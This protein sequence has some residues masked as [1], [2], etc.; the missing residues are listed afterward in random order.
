MS[1]QNKKKAT[2]KNAPRGTS[3]ETLLKSIGESL[4]AERLLQD[5]SLQESQAGSGVSYITISQIER[6]LAT[7]VTLSKLHA[8]AKDLGGDLQLS[9]IKP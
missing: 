6:G 8:I 2:G 9:F 1:T 3:P 7:N 5:R 4:M